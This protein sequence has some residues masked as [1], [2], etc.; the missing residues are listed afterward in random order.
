MSLF[1]NL[2]IYLL[3]C[4]GLASLILNQSRDEV[5]HPE[6]FNLVLIGLVLFIIA[7]AASV[8]KHPLSLGTTGMTAGMAMLYRIG[9]GLMVA[10][11]LFTLL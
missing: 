3:V 9:Y 8:R 1:G 4:V 6:A 11:I 2:G 5:S 7:K 10:G